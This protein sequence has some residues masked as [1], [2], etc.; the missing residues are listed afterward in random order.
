MVRGVFSRRLD[1]AD[2][3]S[4]KRL[5]RKLAM[6]ITN[7]AEAIQGQNKIP[8]TYAFTMQSMEPAKSSGASYNT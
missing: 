4:S 5:S 7:Q 2:D 1:Q 8:R 3:F 6:V